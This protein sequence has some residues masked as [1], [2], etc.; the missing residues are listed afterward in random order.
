MATF[1]FALLNQGHVVHIRDWNFGPICSSFT[2]IY[3]IDQGY[4]HVTFGGRKHKLTEGHLYLIPAL[5]THYDHCDSEFHQYYIHLIDRTKH[6]IDYY[7]RYHMPF[8]VDAKPE[9]EHLILRLLQ[10]CPD[11]RLLNPLPATYDTSIGTLDAAKRYQTLPLPL[12]MEI[13]GIILQLL[14]RF[15]AKA[16]PRQKVN[17]DRIVHTLYTIEQN[18][19][20]I[21]DIEHLA[22]DVNLGKDRFIRLFRQQT[23]YTPT[24]YII[25]HRIHQ[26]QM[27]F[28]DGQRS[29]KEVALSLGYDNISY[30]G[31]LFK[32]VTDITPSEFIRQNK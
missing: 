2:R 32:K 24:D 9:D 5:T 27:L 15:F 6:I 28:I 23:G 29:V 18:L 17:D 10:L 31:R 16:T 8:E 19:A 11:I 21:P 13:N 20:E 26:A 30:F 3:W 7:H 25:R 12:R 1:D 14:S 4:A 22:T